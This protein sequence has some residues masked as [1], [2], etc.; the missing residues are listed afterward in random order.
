MLDHLIDSEEARQLL[1]SCDG[2]IAN[3][4]AQGT[5][6]TSIFDLAIDFNIVEF[7]PCAASFCPSPSRMAH[8]LSPCAFALLSE[9]HALWTG[10]RSCKACLT[11]CGWDAHLRQARCA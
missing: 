2:Q 5:R 8:P 11:I 4:G 3:V 7:Y 6:L 10:T 1:M 9:P